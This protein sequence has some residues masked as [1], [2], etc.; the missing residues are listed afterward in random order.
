MRQ[1]L[2]KLAPPPVVYYDLKPCTT[3]IT[4]VNLKIHELHNMLHVNGYQSRLVGHQTSIRPLRML[5]HGI[6]LGKQ[7]WS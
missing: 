3:A 4:I 1:T 2:G 6:F 5:S 7:F